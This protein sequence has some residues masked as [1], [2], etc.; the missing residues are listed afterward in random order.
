[1]PKDF[2]RTPL[3]DL[4]EISILKLVSRR[5]IIRTLMLDHDMDRKEAAKLYKETVVM[6]TEDEYAL[7]EEEERAI[8]MSSLRKDHAAAE[9]TGDLKEKVKIKREYAETRDILSPKRIEVSVDR[10]DDRTHGQVIADILES[11][12]L[13]EEEHKVKD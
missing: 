12:D 8:R 7:S 6:I 3:M 13:V 10:V 1:M 5:D 11:L 9:A 2:N 4:V